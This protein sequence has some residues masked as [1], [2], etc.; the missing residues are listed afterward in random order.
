MIGSLFLSEW[1][2]AI[3]W[4]EIPGAGEPIV[5]LPAISRA[6]LP[7]FLPTLLDP[8]MQDHRVILVDFVGSG[9]SGHSSTFSCGLEDHAASVCA[10]L[11]HLHLDRMTVVGHSMGGS[12]AISLALE[13]PE[14]IKRLVAFEANILPG[15]GVSTKSILAQTC[16]EF[17]R[18]WP[19]LQ[20]RT[21][22][23]N[24][25][26][27]SPLSN[28]LAV[29]RNGADPA[30]LYRNAVSLSNISES[31]QERFLA[32]EVE[33]HFVWGEKTFPGNTGE[34]TADAPDPELL[35]RG[36]VNIHVLPGTGHALMVERPREAARL[37]ADILAG[38]V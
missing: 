7:N 38:H 36:G 16:D 31:F 25:M 17:V 4:F 18:Q 21:A 13:H 28:F 12:V 30:A 10:I 27:N 32:L 6:V 11:D 26:A 8:C 9:M 35:Q 2:V 29:S 19:E 22:R 34:I 33:R 15:G 14:R 1:D 23:D 24:A 37:L 20:E 5:C 3:R